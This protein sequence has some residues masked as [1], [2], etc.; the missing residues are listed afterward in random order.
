MSGRPR[1]RAAGRDVCRRASKRVEARRRSAPKST[2]TEV[3][4]G[5]GRTARLEAQEGDGRAVVEEL[6]T[7]QR[8]RATQVDAEDVQELRSKNRQLTATIR[9]YKAFVENFDAEEDEETTEVV[10]EQFD[11]QSQQ[12]PSRLKDGGAGDA[13]PADKSRGSSRTG[14]VSRSGG[15]S[16][17]KRPKTDATQNLRH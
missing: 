5:G 4:R 12:T 7:A 2:G 13:G 6:N 1:S 10:D 11:G 16:T 15:G 9:K 17:T 3:Q 14:A 8:E